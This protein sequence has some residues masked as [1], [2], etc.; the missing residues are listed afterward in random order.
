MTPAKKPVK[1]T[2]FYCHH[3]SPIPRSS[4]HLAWIER[5]AQAITQEVEGQHGQDDHDTWSN[6]K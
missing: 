4:L 6:G 3:T 5:I 1:P 2:G